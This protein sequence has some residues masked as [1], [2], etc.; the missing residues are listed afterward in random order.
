MTTVITYLWLTDFL[1]WL[2]DNK[3]YT[4]SRML[5]APIAKLAKYRQSWYATE[6]PCKINPLYAPHGSE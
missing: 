3:E 6:N 5:N 4:Y 1:I 2:T